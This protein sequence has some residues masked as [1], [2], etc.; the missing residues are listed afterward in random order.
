MLLYFEVHIMKGM[1]FKIHIMKSE[2]ILEC[3]LWSECILEYIL[4][5]ECILNYIL[6]SILKYNIHSLMV[7]LVLLFLITIPKMVYFWHEPFDLWLYKSK[8][9]FWCLSRPPVKLFPHNTT[10][11]YQILFW[12]LMVC[13]ILIW[14]VFWIVKIVSHQNIFGTTF[15]QTMFSFAMHKRKLWLL[16]Y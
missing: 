6:W 9:L 13:S 12:I 14:P 3:I 7:N 2:C 5:S 15:R 11:F 4:W 8:Q 1:Y 16:S 10:Y